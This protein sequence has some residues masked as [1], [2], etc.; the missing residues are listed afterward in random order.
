[1]VKE[2][3]GAMPRERVCRFGAARVREYRDVS[4][5]LRR[6]GIG[7]VLRMWLSS[8]VGRLRRWHGIAMSLSRCFEVENLRFDAIVESM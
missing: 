2:Q 4:L 1:M 5:N 3:R 7:R 6:E 8:S